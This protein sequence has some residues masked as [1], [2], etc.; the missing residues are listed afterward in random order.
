V[1]PLEAEDG[2][3]M[4]DFLNSVPIVDIVILL[5]FLA[6]LLLGV[7]QGAIRRILGIVSIVLAFLVAANLRDTLG[8]YLAQ[9]WRQ[10]DLEY[11]RLLAFSIAFSVGVV[12]SSVVIQGFYKRAEIY[13]KHPIV[14]DVV[15]GLL[16]LAQGIL[17]LIVAV[18]I[19]DSSVLPSAQS[20]DVSQLRYA[21]DLIVNQSHIA[22]AIRHA[23]APSFVH[24]FSFLL[25]SDLVS[26]F[27]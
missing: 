7:M 2:L 5:G 21:H 16:G 23:V 11:N 18:V 3:D 6:A 27:P 25:P 4:V 26:L 24:I 12:I 19:F 1:S 13:A 17:L 15:G 20:G 9:N 8:D 14:D 10:F 22:D